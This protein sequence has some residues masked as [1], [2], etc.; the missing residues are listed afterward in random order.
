MI[1]QR[2]HIGCSL[3]ANKHDLHLYHTPKLQCFS[4][5]QSGVPT[6]I[7]DVSGAGRDITLCPAP[8]VFFRKGVY[9][10]P[11][12]C[13]FNYK[14]KKKKSHI[15]MCEQ[16][17]TEEEEENPEQQKQL[18]EDQ[19]G[20]GGKRQDEKGPGRQLAGKRGICVMVDPTLYL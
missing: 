1:N 12:M 5:I 7:M 18:K 11:W 10:H 4:L 17:C 14:L 2:K 8:F 3:G 6:V 16:R 19:G 9:A 13:D 15:H 20:G